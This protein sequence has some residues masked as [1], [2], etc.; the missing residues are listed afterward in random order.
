MFTALARCSRSASAARRH[1]LAL[2]RLHDRDLLSTT[3][4]SRLSGRLRISAQA[5]ALTAIR[6]RP[7]NTR[8]PRRSIIKNAFQMEILA[9]IFGSHNSY[10]I[11]SLERKHLRDGMLLP[12][13]YL[14]GLGRGQCSQ[15]KSSSKLYESSTRDA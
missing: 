12:G 4:Y 14:H 1:T 8:L 5:G 15:E 13:R 10:F 9:R 6:R 2:A 7:A 11:D 3:E